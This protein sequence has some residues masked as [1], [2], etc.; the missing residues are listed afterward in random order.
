M[1]NVS[2]VYYF[3]P[4]LRFFVPA[5]GPSGNAPLHGKMKVPPLKPP[6]PRLHVMSS[7]VEP[8]GKHYCD[9]QIAGSSLLL[10]TN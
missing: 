3:A 2:Y 8:I 5:N 6:R 10:G 1:P 4:E 7:F 9:R